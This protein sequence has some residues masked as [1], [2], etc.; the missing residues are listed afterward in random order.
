V[1]VLDSLPYPLTKSDLK[2]IRDFDGI[3]GIPAG[4]TTWGEAPGT[5]IIARGFV[6]ETSE[7][8][9]AVVEDADAGAYRILERS[10]GAFQAYREWCGKNGYGDDAGGPS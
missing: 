10:D 2:K 6:I 8:T 1:T 3:E 5:D 9:V 4:V 7:T